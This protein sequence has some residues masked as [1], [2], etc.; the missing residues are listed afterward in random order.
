MLKSL[1]HLVYTTTSV[2]KKYKKRMQSKSNSNASIS[3]KGF[4]KCSVKNMCNI[5]RRKT[6][7]GEKFSQKV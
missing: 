4:L 1:Q 6:K 2:S 7:Y 5:A 3:N